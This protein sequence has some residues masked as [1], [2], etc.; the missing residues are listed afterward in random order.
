MDENKG[1]SFHHE[2]GF[3]EKRMLYKDRHHF[4]Q[5]DGKTV[6]LTLSNDVLY[7]VWTINKFKIMFDNSLIN[8]LSIKFE[9]ET[10]NDM[11]FT[12][13]LG[14][15]LM[16]QKTD[17]VIKNPN[18]FRI[19]EM[20]KIKY[21]NDTNKHYIKDK[22]NINLKW[23][24]DS[25]VSYYCIFRCIITDKGNKVEFIARTFNNIYHINNFIRHED[26]L[27]SLISIKSIGHDQT[28]CEGESIIK[29]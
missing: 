4:Q 19:T 13:L 16:F 26:E 21:D 24:K 20:D 3:V 2:E 11:A 23:S 15:F 18:N 9:N 27:Y 28:V 14:G 7:N 17:M 1:L 10:K 29:I 22:L 5:I 12:M 25:N 6:D 8:K